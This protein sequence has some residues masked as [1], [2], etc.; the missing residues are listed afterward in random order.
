MRPTLDQLEIFL[1]VVDAGSFRAAAKRLG[2]TQSTISY[3]VTQL[4]AGLERQ[5]FERTGGR[6]RLTRAG[7]EVAARAR[8]IVGEANRLAD[9]LERAPTALIRQP[10]HVVV[11]TIV[12][13]RVLVPLLKAAGERLPETEL[14]V[15]TESKFSLLE[16]L[17]A[18]EAD[19]ALSGSGAAVPAGLTREAL[20]TF[21]LVPVVSANH[22]LARVRGL[23]SGVLA[24]YPQ[25]AVTERSV[26]GRRQPF[27]NAI[28]ARALRVTELALKL[29][30]IRAGAGWGYL[31]FDAVS[32]DLRARTLVRLR[33]PPHDVGTLSLIYPSQRGPTA[34]GRLVRERL[35]PRPG[36]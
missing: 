29:D 22:P 2:R 34:F 23:T 4:E 30:L 6:P 32:V 1:C 18:G 8:A 26:V 20:R 28:G 12:P 19:V 10:L 24:S 14:I 31:P 17:G 13:S 9:P 36:R 3:A 27:E 16:L 7:E 25:I 11:D 33:S 5:V 15:R 35:A 21:A